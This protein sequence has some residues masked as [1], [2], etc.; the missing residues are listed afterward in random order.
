MGEEMWH[1]SNKLDRSIIA[2]HVSARRLAAL[3]QCGDQ[4]RLGSLSAGSEDLK[5][6]LI[7]LGCY[8]D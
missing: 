4:A 7:R 2:F 8:N 1:S 3:T 5:N 6:I